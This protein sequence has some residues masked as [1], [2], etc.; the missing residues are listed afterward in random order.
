MMREKKPEFTSIDY[1]VFYPIRWH[2]IKD[3]WLHTKVSVPEES[4]LFQY[5]YTTNRYHEIFAWRNILA[6]FLIILSFMVLS[7]SQSRSKNFSYY[8]GGFLLLAIVV[9]Y[10]FIH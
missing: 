9:K 10:N 5:G 3:P 1:S 6:L 2:N 8:L 7:I 4:L